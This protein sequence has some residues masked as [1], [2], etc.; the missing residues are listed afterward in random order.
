MHLAREVRKKAER[1]TRAAAYVR[2]PRVLTDPQQDSHQ[3]VYITTS[4]KRCKE[5]MQWWGRLWWEWYLGNTVKGYLAHKK[6]PP[7]RTLQ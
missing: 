6:T 5:E 1:E 3:E 4:D 7:P 2:H